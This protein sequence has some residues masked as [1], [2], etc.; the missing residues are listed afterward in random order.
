MKLKLVKKLNEA[1]GT[2]SFFWEPSTKVDFLP[3]QYYYYTLPNLKFED[4]RGPTRHFTISSSPTE[5][6]LLRLT[7]RI[8]QES[9]YKRTLDSLNLGDEIDGEGP[10]GTFI[11]DEAEKPK[12]HILLAG[13]IGVTPFRAF[14]KYNLDKNLEIP[15][16][17]IYSNSD[18]EFVFGKELTEWTKQNRYLKAELLDSSKTGHL[19]NTTVKKLVEN[20]ELRIENLTFWVSGPPA[21]VRA[22]EAELDK[23][24]VSSNKVNTDKFTGY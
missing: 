21:F 9:G 16:Y 2:K 19:D 3:G 12:T 7:T 5:G 13:G 11:L 17:L 8:R 24:K 10:S 1:R 20:W 22:M 4:S 15:M 14:M 23:L 18:S 6:N